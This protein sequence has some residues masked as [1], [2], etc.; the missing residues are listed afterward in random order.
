[1]RARFH[2]L[3]VAAI[4]QQPHFFIFPWEASVDA[5]APDGN[6]DK[7]SIWLFTLSYTRKHIHCKCRC[8]PEPGSW[9][10]E[11]G[12]KEGKTKVD[13]NLAIKQIGRRIPAVFHPSGHPCGYTAQHECQEDDPGKS[14][15]IVCII[16]QSHCRQFFFCR[17]ERKCCHLRKNEL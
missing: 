5:N 6:L 14:E 9:I 16:K 7:Q 17:I 8:Q 3:Y 11:P 1:M 15:I 13:R 10:A 4:L 12:G 2:I